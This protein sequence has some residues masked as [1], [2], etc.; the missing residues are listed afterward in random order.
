M[1]IKE[2][3][4]GSGGKVKKEDSD[5]EEWTKRDEPSYEVAGKIIEALQKEGSPLFSPGGDGII[6]FQNSGGKIGGKVVG[7]L[8]GVGVMVVGLL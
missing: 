7:A 2:A 4:A 6:G 3:L 8:V 5:E 1:N